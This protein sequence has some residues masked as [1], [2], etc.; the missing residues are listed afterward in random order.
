MP[1]LVKLKVHQDGQK[2]HVGRVE[3]E[4]DGGGTDV[5]GGGHHTLH[6]HRPAHRVVDSVMF[7]NS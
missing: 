7:G 5:I 4:V 6:H 2:I 1:A 3:L